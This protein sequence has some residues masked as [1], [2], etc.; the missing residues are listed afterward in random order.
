MNVR[1][2]QYRIEVLERLDVVPE[3]HQ[4]PP[5]PWTDDCSQGDKYDGCFTAQTQE[6]ADIQLLMCVGH[7]LRYGKRYDS[8]AMCWRKLTWA[9]AFW[10][11]RDNIAWMAFAKDVGCGDILQREL[12]D[13]QYVTVQR[14]KYR[15]HVQQLFKARLPA[16][17]IGGANPDNTATRVAAKRSKNAK[18]AGVVNWERNHPPHSQAQATLF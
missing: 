13:G 7:T 14:T 17:I 4:Y 6:D 5:T 9:E 11:E 12:V 2:E 10:R 3:P 1:S 15:D 16:G 18:N 8:E